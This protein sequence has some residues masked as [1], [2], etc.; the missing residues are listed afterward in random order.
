MKRHSCQAMK[1]IAKASESNR[2]SL[3]GTVKGE[4]TSMATSWPFSAGRYWSKG[5]A[6]MLYKVLAKG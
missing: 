4:S 1:G 5:V 2:V 6:M 3:S